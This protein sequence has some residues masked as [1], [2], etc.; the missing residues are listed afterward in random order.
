M[1]RTTGLLCFALGMLFCGQ[2]NAADKLVLLKNGQPA[3]TIV[4]DPRGAVGEGPAIL[5]DAGNWLAESL[6]AAS[7]AKLSMAASPGDG[8]A[9]IIA[10][11][12]A[13]P[14]V[15]AEIGF[16]P[17]GYS[18]YAIVTKP[19]RVLVL[20]EGEA[21]ARDGVASLL[22][23]WGFRWFAPSPK[24]HIAPRLTDLTVDL[25][26]IETPALIDRRIWYAYGMSGEDLK[27]L[28]D[29]YARW[30]IANRLSLKSPIRTGHSYGN[31]I[32]RNTAAFDM[33]P[34]LSAQLTD[35]T[36]DT[37]RHYNAR[38]FCYSNPDLI[39]LVTEDRWKLLTE[40]RT[41]NPA[42]YMVSVDP[43]DGEGTC[44]CPDCRALGTTTDRVFHL[45]NAVARGLRAKDPQAWV[46]LYAYSSHRLPP[47]IEVEPNVYVQVAMGFNRT[48]FS[49]PE[50]V[51][52]WSKKVGAIGLR[53]YYGVEAWDWGLPGR[54][55]G[56][57]VSY[58]QK[59]IPFYAERK[60]NA[61][62][63]ETNA[64]WGAQT[65]GLYVAAQ[66]MWDPKAD[67]AAIVDEFFTLAFGKAAPAMRAFFD[68][69]E[70]A[71]PLQPSTLLPMFADL[72]TAS[73]ATDDRA[74]QERLTDLKAYLV[75][76]AKFREFDLVQERNRERNDAYY[77][78]LAPLMNYAWRIRHR[79]T[80]HYY[81]LARRLCNGQPVQDGRLEFYLANKDRT[82]VWQ[83]GESLSDAE[84]DALFAD[85]AARLKSDGDP[86]VPFSRYLDRVTAPGEDAGPS[87]VQ[88]DPR[89]AVSRFRRGL[90][91]YLAAS[92][93]MT[94]RL[95]LAPTSKPVTVTVYLREEPVYEREF[96]AAAEMH[97]LAIELPRAF[98]YRLQISGD[99]VLRVPPETP[100]AYEA[101]T[102]HPAWIDYSGPH[103]FYVPR[104]T[105][106]VIVDA[107][108]RLS[109]VVPGEGKRDVGPA[110]RVEG[111]N[112]I[113]IKVPSGADGKLWHTTSLTRGQISLLNI[114]PLLS[115][116]SQTVLVP[117]EVSEAEGL[118]TRK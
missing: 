110:D 44:D 67:V 59:W 73:S 35:G 77:A 117:R 18:A 9:L 65:L 13:W 101:S 87:R 17:T 30:A 33:D 64:N 61:V 25:N 14:E 24:W 115:F 57:R 21:A 39:R 95:G 49:L 43:S 36:R 113:T 66:L 45:A 72:E 71:P 68:K 90:R 69:M 50:L 100:L 12:D 74:V 92:G 91:G 4:V 70:A 96:Q 20:G 51:D 37:K 5:T 56:G 26:V 112:Y 23:R 15:A 46:G 82:P 10:R 11:A 116:H 3:A 8:P 55:R 118:T 75:Y 53:E 63:A 86:T 60:L 7:G 80:I 109:L 29:H 99:F 93:P 105:K 98:E 48:E 38:K 84:V 76:V 81:A 2:A 79:D 19:N 88:G 22:R 62:N 1:K 108:P 6:Q 52:R 47:T 78:A 111:K 83:E 34:G 106:E 102:M 107:S 103:Y 27:P 54:A 97:E 28:M 31:I 94:A 104:G 41:A 42:A 114:P 32:Q 40:E 16:K 85:T 58:H 89:E